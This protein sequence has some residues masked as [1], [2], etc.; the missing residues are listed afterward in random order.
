MSKN[1]NKQIEKMIDKNE[2]YE[3]DEKDLTTAYLLACIPP[4]L[5]FGAHK[6]YLGEHTSGVIYFFAWWTGIW[7]LIWFISDLVTMKD[8]V[9]R[10]NQKIKLHNQIVRAYLNEYT[11]SESVI[12]GDH[13]NKL[14]TKKASVE[15]QI[16]NL[17]QEK[18][19]RITAT[20]VAMNTE[21]TIEEADKLLKKLAESS[22]VSMEV[23]DKG[24]IYYEFVELID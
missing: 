1:K 17:A 13:T 2:M 20:D 16:L 10:A 9:K 4:L 19:G 21:L 22:Y 18:N 12:K 15:D 23:S 8:K 11:E 3:K 24:V 5:P 14:I 7:G 6:H